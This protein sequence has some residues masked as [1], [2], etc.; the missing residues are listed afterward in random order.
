M[1]YILHDEY[2]TVVVKVLE[3]SISTLLLYCTSLQSVQPVGAWFFHC[4]DSELRGRLWVLAPPVVC[5]QKDS[6]GG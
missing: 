6:T 4:T 2:F 5:V 1:N 3:L